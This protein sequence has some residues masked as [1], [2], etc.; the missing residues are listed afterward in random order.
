VRVSRGTFASAAELAVLAGGN[1]VA[2]GDGSTDRWEVFQYANAAPVEP[3]VWELQLRLR[4]QAGT[5]GIVPEVWPAGSVVVALDRAVE[6]I[7]FAPGNRGLARHYRIGT[8]ARGYDD[9]AVVHRVDAFAGV[10][11]R[12]YAP[13][14]LRQT[15][16]ASGDR[17]TWVRRTRVDGDSWQSEEVPLGEA[18]ERYRVR[19]MQGSVVKRE[20][21]VTVPEWVYPTAQRAADGVSG[22]LRLEV[23]QVSDRYGPG[24]FKGI[25]LDD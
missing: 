21:D 8:A 5:D 17:F 16:V 14:H 22:A 23:A 25:E 24:P 12:P 7:T 2:I 6:Q 4:G 15:A 11:L 20:V 9:P 10:G 1:A 18:S 19:V 3:G 13:A